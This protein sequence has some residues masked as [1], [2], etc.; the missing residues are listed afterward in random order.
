MAASNAKAH[1]FRL[2]WA[3]DD[4]RRRMGADAPE[5]FMECWDRL[6]R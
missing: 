3:M 6:G 1:P 2:P 4:G 5:G